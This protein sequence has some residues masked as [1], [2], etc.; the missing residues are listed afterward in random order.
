MTDIHDFAAE[1]GL[2][3]DYQ[4]RGASRGKWAP[5][6]YVSIDGPTGSKSVEIKEGA[7]L[8]SPCGNGDTPFAA[9]RDLARQLS[10]QRIVI[11]AS[12]PSRREFVAPYLK[13]TRLNPSTR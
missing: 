1:H 12:T 5:E 3:L 7:V 9:L 4:Q 13:A 8:S 6:Y 10:R 11:G 2:T